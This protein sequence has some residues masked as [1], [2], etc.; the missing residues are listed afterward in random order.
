MTEGEP[1][2]MKDRRA[3]RSW[4][5]KNHRSRDET[6]LLFFKKHTGKQSISYEDA[7]EEA[8]CFGWIDGRLKRIDDQ[9][10]M[11]RF[12]PRK[13]GSRWS[14]SNIARAE[15]MIDAGCMTE[16]GLEAYRGAMRDGR[17]VPSSGNFTVPEDLRAALEKTRGVA[18]DYDGLAP[19]TRLMIAHW[20]DS[21]RTPETRR[22]RIRR[23]IELIS[24]SARLTTSEFVSGIMGAG[25]RGSP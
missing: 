9:K 19:S 12:T 3:W 10:H 2:L 13:T 16:H 24:G 5:E 20:V 4:L 21:A 25:R 14:E 18:E 11:Q 6:W 17:T 22:K 15:K 7:V 8:V 23:S 1:L